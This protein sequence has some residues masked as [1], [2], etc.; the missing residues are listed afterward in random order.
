M[1]MAN[2]ARVILAI[3]ACSYVVRNEISLSKDKSNLFLSVCALNLLLSY[4]HVRTY[5]VFGRSL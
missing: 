2:E 3:R 1:Q 5:D 4:I